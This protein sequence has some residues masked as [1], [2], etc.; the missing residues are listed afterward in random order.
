MNWP[1]YEFQQAQTFSE[2][3][4]DAESTYILWQQRM[5]VLPT[6]YFPKLRVCSP[7]K[8]ELLAFVLLKHVHVG[9]GSKLSGAC[10][11]STYIF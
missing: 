3:R 2:P 5:A 8:S 9:S 11:A 6:V 4:L 7:E 10:N 1:K